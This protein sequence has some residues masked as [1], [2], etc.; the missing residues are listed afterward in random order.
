[1]N[2]IIESL[3]LNSTLVAQIFNFLILFLFLK[4]VVYKPIVNVLEKRQQLIQDNV[5]SAEDERKEAQALHQRYMDEMKKAKEDAHEV[6]QKAVKSGETQAQQIIEAAKGESDRIKENALR[7]IERAKEKA[8]LELRD[9]VAT[10]SILVAD[11]IIGKQ[12]TNELQHDLVKEFIE[13]AG[14]LPC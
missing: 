1:M 7:D 14:D 12:I 10:L 5:K 6:I 11:K 3:G 4:V 13:E 2:A 8:V 9:Q